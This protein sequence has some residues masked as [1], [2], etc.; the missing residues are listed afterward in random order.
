M[1]RRTAFQIPD[2]DPERPKVPDVVPLIEALYAREPGGCCLHV[3][4]GGGNYGSA[5]FCARLAMAA[6]HDRCLEL[7]RVLGKMT[8]TQRRKAN[9]LAKR[10]YKE[11]T[12][13]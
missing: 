7:A 12:W 11:T 10:N 1:T 5:E 6:K 2:F 9:H 8:L 3:M 4:L 13:K